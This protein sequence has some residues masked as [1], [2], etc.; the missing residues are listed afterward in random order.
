MNPLHSINDVLQMVQ[1]TLGPSATVT[2]IHK[3]ITLQPL[4]VLDNKD[5]AYYCQI[6][7]P[8]AIPLGIHIPIDH[9]LSNDLFTTANVY[10]AGV[11]SQ[12]MWFFTRLTNIDNVQPV[13]IHMHGYRIDYR[14]QT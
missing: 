13:G 9:Y 1:E 2:P 3:I 11:P 7:T 6:R 8:A 14:R 10:E 5:I 4:E 12:N